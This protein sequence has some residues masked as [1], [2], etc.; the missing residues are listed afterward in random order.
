MYSGTRPVA[1]AKK[2]D[3]VAL[4]QHLPESKR[5]QYHDLAVNG[6]VSD[7]ASDMDESESSDDDDN[8]DSE[9]E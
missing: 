8:G 1:V 2:A 7:S 5:Q 4:A 9:Q 6:D 3:L